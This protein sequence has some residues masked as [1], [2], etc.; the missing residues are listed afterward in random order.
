MSLTEAIRLRSENE[1]KAFIST[2]IIFLLL[3][4]LMFLF[5]LSTSVKD[6]FEGGIVVDFGTTETGLGD[7]NSSLG[8]PASG[9]SELPEP[10]T[11]AVTS[12]APSPAPTPTPSVKPVMTADNQEIALEKKKKQEEERLKKEEETRKKLQAEAD[13]K[14]KAEAERKRLEEER[15][16]KEEEEFKNKMAQ[17]IKGIKGSGSGGQGTGK[18]EGQ[19]TPGGNQ[20]DPSGTPG[21]PKGVGTGSGAGTSGIGFDLKGRNMVS[22]P[23]VNNESQKYGKVVVRITVDRRGNVIDATFIQSGSTTNDSYLVNL[24]IEAAKRAKFS[25]DA[26]AADEQFGTITF[27]YKIAQ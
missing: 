2:V 18:G 3:L 7:D 19:S 20:G 14:A 1:R 4:L 17:G 22:A 16:L 21:A 15:K 13:A 6:K 24:S 27:N 11:E 8:E 25:E 9:E 10:T 26:Q 23:R 12:P 5:K